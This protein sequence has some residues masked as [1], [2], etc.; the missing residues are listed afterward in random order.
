M[1]ANIVITDAKVAPNPVDAGKQILISVGIADMVYAILTNDNYYIK[2]ED[3]KAISR[4][5]E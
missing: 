4:P 5:T 3:G 2:T 1:A